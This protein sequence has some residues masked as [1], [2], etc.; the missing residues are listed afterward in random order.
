LVLP[1]SLS[2]A[3][4]AFPPHERGTAIGIWSAAG[5]IGAG[6]GP[7]LGGLLI[8]ASWRWIFLINVPIVLVAAVAGSLLIPRDAIVRGGV[9]FDGVGLVLLLAAM[10]LV[11]AGLLESAVWPAL[12]IWSVL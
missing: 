5:A 3:L 1:T 9:R 11:C 6:A 7:V 4:P 8:Q 12:L 10:G 2:L